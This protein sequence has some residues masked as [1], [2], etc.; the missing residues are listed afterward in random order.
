MLPQIAQN[1]QTLLN[2]NHPST[3]LSIPNRFSVNFRPQEQLFS[4]RP[5]TEAFIQ[6]C[7][8]ETG[9]QFHFSE[10]F[11]HSFHSE[12]IVNRIYSLIKIGNPVTRRLNKFEKALG[13][14]EP[15]NPNNLTF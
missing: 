4:D 10:K 2:Q 3:I 8:L 11:I 14:I 7:D 1:L 13:I 15:R 9:T 5:P 12:G 6:I